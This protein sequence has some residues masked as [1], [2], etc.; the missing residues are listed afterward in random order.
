MGDVGDRIIDLALVERPAAPVGKARS[1][2]EA[3]TEQAFYQIGIADLLAMP[4][5]HCRDLRVE[6]G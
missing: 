5:R 6:Q 2:V 3:V 4:E 1:L